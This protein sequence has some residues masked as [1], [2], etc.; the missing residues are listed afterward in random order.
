MNTNAYVGKNVETLFKNSIGDHP[1]V[2][3]KIR[4]AF[5]ING[6]FENAIP[7]GLHAEKVDVKIAFNCGRNIDV[8]IKSYKKSAGY[9]QLTRTSLKKFCEIFNLECFEYLQNRFISK[10]LRA[11][12]NLIPIIHQKEMLSIFQPIA[13]EIVKWSL[14]YKLSR[15][16]LVLYE[17][18]DSIM[19][20]YV[21]KN[22]LDS[23]CYRFCFTKKGNMMIGYY[24]VIQRKGGNGAHS[25]S[26]PKD[27]IEHPGNN[28]QIKLKINDFVRGMEKY[29]L[30]SYKI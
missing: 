27:S 30:A 2:I 21:M 8:N 11:N 3:N 6:N 17:R 23:L 18:E 24:I 13:K 25:K 5:K 7:T 19:H 4:S 15:E 14:S 16:M 20:I 29:K 12:E 26:V 22:I 9:N 28:I 10:S 1:S